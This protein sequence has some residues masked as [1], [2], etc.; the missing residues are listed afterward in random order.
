MF[1]IT[2]EMV[3]TERTRRLEGYRRWSHRHGYVA[4]VEA[5]DPPRPSHG[6]RPL[7]RAAAFSR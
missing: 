7:L 1:P 3:T 5:N 6:H 4:G 2:N